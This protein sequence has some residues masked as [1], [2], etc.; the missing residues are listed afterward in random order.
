VV[1]HLNTS[2]KSTLFFRAKLAASS[3]VKRLGTATMNPC[4]RRGLAV[5]T[6]FFCSLVCS[7]IAT[8]Q[9]PTE[10]EPSCR[11]GF[12]CVQGQ[13]VSACNPPCSADEQCVNSDCVRTNSSSTPAPAASASPQSGPTPQAPS[14]LPLDQSAPVPPVPGT[15]VPAAQA[16]PNMPV[17]STALAPSSVQTPKDPITNYLIIYPSYSADGS[18]SS[19]HHETSRG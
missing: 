10:C 1:D 4:R 16:Q 18:S 2:G 12:I 5:I 6:T 19:I 3:S 11:S 15:V 14:A 9:D 8:A 17:A 7:R 13:C